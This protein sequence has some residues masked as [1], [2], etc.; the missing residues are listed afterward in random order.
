[1]IYRIVAANCTPYLAILVALLNPLFL[2]HPDVGWRAWLAICEQASEF[3][4]VGP[5]VDAGDE[6]TDRSY[7]RQECE[8]ASEEQESSIPKDAQFRA[9]LKKDAN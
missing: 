8:Q 7:T 2:D 9:V 3:R 1:M 4:L 6:R 5:F